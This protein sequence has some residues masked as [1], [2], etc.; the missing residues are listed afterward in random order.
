MRIIDDVQTTVS[1]AFSE[2]YIFFFIILLYYF[3]DGIISQYA[4]T[5]N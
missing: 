4:S 5:I 1:L 2:F 3:V